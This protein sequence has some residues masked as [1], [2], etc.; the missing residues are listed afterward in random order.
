MVLMTISEVP[1]PE[2]NSEFVFVIVDLLSGVLII[3][4]V[5]GNIG[6]MIANTNA[7]RSQ[8]QHRLDA[9]KTY[10]TFRKVRH[11][12]SSLSSRDNVPSVVIF[13]IVVVRLV[14]A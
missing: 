12:H 14:T 9:I 8:F 5:V 7:M 1:R 2:T 11:P 3:A 4:T 10:L 13:R 6:S